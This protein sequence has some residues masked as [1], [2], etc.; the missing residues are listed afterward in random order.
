MGHGSGSRGVLFVAGLTST[1]AHSEGT[2][3]QPTAPPTAP[4]TL[5]DRLTGHWSGSGRVTGLESSIEMAWEPVVGAR[6]VRLTFRN[7]MATAG[8]PRVFE[9]HAYYRATASD[10]LTGT[11]FD[12]RGLVLPIVA[13]ATGS[14][15][16]ST[17]GTP[18][19]EQGRT[20]YRLVG[21]D[22]L[23]LIDSVRTKTGMREFGRSALRR[24]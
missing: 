4:P 7:T 20:I 8:A 1:R 5:L 23:E 17:W 22:S 12:S 10:S 24:K 13:T 19:T 18:D 15:L 9:G 14:A 16:E 6:F 3:A 21:A 11:W 2:T